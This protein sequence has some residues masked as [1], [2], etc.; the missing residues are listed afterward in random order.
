MK[1]MKERCKGRKEGRKKQ[2][3]RNK[4]GRVNN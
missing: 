4:E 2:E 3:R 1:E